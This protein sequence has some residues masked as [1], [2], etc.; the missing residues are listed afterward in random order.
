MPPTRDK[1]GDFWLDLAR[2]HARSGVRANQYRQTA[3]TE[4][5]RRA[6]TAS[7]PF[8]ISN[9]LLAFVNLAGDEGKDLM[10]KDRAAL[11]IAMPRGCLADAPTSAMNPGKPI[12]GHD[13]VNDD[14][15]A[16]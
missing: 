4:S 9:P 13:A 12:T 16:S 14:L 3:M 2:S 6:T 1:T 15:A 10:A 5:E 7:N 8:I 11:A